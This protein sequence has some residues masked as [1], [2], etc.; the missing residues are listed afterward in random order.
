MWDGRQKQDPVLRDKHKL[1]QYVDSV[2]RTQMHSAGYLQDKI[3]P[4]KLYMTPCR[5][6]EY[7]LMKRDCPPDT[8]ATQMSTA[9]EVE[10]TELN[11]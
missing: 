4:T 11:D 8:S 9:G 10:V 6:F 3:Y 5:V 1:I 2:L 7:L